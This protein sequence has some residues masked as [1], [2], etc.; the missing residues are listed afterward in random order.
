M[1]KKKRGPQSQLAAAMYAL[2]QRR[3]QVWIPFL[4]DKVKVLQARLEQKQEA[5]NQGPKAG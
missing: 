3:V 5:G 2:N 4:E 1:A